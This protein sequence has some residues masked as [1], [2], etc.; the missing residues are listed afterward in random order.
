MS[1][2]EEWKIEAEN[3]DVPFENKTHGIKSFFSILYFLIMHN[4]CIKIGAII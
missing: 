2:I 4:V 3:I 1:N